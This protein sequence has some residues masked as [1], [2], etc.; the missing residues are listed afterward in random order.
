MALQ[1][2]TQSES[3]IHIE[4]YLPREFHSKKK[5]KKKTY[6]FIIV[7]AAILIKLTKIP[8]YSYSI[9]FIYMRNA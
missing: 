2:E 4:M 1:T 8:C 5:N 9:V 6:C 3:K 7:D